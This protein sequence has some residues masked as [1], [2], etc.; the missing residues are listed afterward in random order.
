MPNTRAC[1]HMKKPLTIEKRLTGKLLMQK[2]FSTSNSF[3]Y[4]PT[5]EFHFIYEY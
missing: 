1:L 5:C 3:K 2:I 4:L